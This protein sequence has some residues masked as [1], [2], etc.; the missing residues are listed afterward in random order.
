MKNETKIIIILSTLL[1][2]SWIFIGYT[3]VS[4][5][6]K[7]KYEELYRKAEQDYNSIKQE[8]D[9][10]GDVHKQLQDSQQAYNTIKLERDKLSAARADDLRRR[11][12]LATTADE[13]NERVGNTLGESLDLIREFQRE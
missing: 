3:R 6:D 4:V 10:I 13:L 2:L 7:G 11:E 8:L 9:A 5:S 1:L 12:A